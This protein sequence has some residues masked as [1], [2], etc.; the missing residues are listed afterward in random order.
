MILP[1]GS[2]GVVSQ[3]A[4]KMRGS[5]EITPIPGTEGGRNVTY[6]PDG[7][8]IAYVVGT[9][10]FKRPLVGGPPPSAWR[11]IRKGA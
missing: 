9:E 8:W 5:T 11:K 3:L 2:A 4:L 7:Q 1:I 6:S 10:L